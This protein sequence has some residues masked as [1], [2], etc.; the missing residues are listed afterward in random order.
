MS[1]SNWK[2]V[3]KRKESRLSTWK[4]SKLRMRKLSFRVKRKQNN[5]SFNLSRQR[6]SLNSCSLKSHLSKKSLKLNSKILLSDKKNW[7]KNWVKC[8]VLIAK[9]SKTITVWLKR[10]KPSK[11]QIKLRWSPRKRTISRK[12]WSGS[13]NLTLINKRLLF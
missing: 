4:V 5:S 6:I 3:M 10:C 12:N 13:S 1:L 7:Q 11:K 2:I 8:K 9:V